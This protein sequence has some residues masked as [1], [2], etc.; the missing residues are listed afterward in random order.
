MRRWWVM[1]SLVAVVGFA[2]A[3]DD[4]KPK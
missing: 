1:L 2:V 3:Q 4:E